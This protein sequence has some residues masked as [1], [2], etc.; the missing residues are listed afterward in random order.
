MREKAHLRVGTY[1]SEVEALLVFNLGIR[2][3][4]GVIALA[5]HDMVLLPGAC[6]L[7]RAALECC[8][9]AAWL[10]DDADPIKRDARWIAHLDGEISAICRSSKRRKKYDANVEAAGEKR[11]ILKK[12]RDDVARELEHR[13]VQLLKRLPNFKQMLSSIGGDNLY[14]V[15][16]ELSQYTH[17]GHAAT[18]LYRGAGVGTVKETGEYIQSGQ[19]ILPLRVCW[20]ALCHP[21]DVVTTRVA[22]SDSA[23]WSHEFRAMIDTLFKDLAFDQSQPLH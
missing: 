10:V 23:A 16:I 5:R 21:G 18:W 6:H 17:G 3:V 7:A 15:Y 4:E 22:R 14:S 1:E 20:L 13:G 2:N 11:R 19:W 12:F 9:R 8:V